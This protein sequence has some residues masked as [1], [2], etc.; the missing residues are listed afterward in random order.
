MRD[1]INVE[2]FKM[3]KRKIFIGIFLLSN[4]SLVYSL[5]IYFNWSFIDING[6][7]DLISFSTSMWAL[8][9][10]LGIPLVLFTFLA[11]GTLGGEISDGQFTLE[12]TRVRSIKSLALGK[13]ISIVEVLVSF[14]ILS[15]ALS[16]LYYIVFVA[17][18]KNGLGISWD[19][20]GYHSRLLLVS[21]CG[22]LFL[23]MFIS[24][25]MVV[26]V[27]FGTFRAV[28]LSLS[29]YVL[30]KFISSIQSIRIW[31]PGYYTLIDDN[32]FSLLIVT[33][34]L[35]IMGFIIGTLIYVT[36]NF[37]EKKDY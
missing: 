4:F 30:L 21:I 22:V 35:F 11:A 32:D 1:V 26:S 18:S 7:L 3:W 36:I 20:E 19:I 6:K 29:I 2:L 10:M 9:M 16:S 25:A 12:I 34:Q 17:R 27:N 13:F 37:L 15:M 31:I 8:L 33:Y 28:L 14:Y 5:G 23:I 24:I